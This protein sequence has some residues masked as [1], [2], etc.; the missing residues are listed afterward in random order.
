MQNA[1]RKEPQGMSFVMKE[2]GAGLE[3][4]WDLSDALAIII[5]WHFGA[6]HSMFFFYALLQPQFVSSSQVIC[7]YAR[8]VRTN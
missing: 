5:I 1:G 8:N 2:V 3:M 4:G 6:G 7:M